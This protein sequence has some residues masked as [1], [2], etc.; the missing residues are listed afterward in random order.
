MYIGIRRRGIRKRMSRCGWR[1]R[2]VCVRYL[3]GSGWG[4][5]GKVSK[6]SLD[7][8]QLLRRQSL[9]SQHVLQI[10]QG[11]QLGLSFWTGIIIRNCGPIPIYQPRDVGEK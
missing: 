4:G 8:L 6:M 5:S 1:R 9:L 10:S 2:V 11:L 3:G 7:G